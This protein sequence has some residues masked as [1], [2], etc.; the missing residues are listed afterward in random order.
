MHCSSPA[1]FVQ[2]RVEKGLGGGREGPEAGLHRSVR[3]RRAGRLRGILRQMGE[4]LPGHHTALGERLGG[5]HSFP[6]VRQRDPHCDLHDKCHRIYKCAAQESGKR[7]RSLPDRAGRPEV[8]VPRRHEPG[9]RRQ[10]AQ[11]VEQPLEGRPE[12]LRYHLRWPP[13]RGTKV[14]EETEVTPLT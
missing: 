13:Q 9:P 5:I 11:A 6:A 8:P 12:R 4:A 2:V 7:A 1:E 10:G 3:G 14:T